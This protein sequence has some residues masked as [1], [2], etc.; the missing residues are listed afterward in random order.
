M[1]LLAH[2][3]LSPPDEII[4]L[5]NVLADFIGRNERGD[6]DPR[7]QVGMELHRK[8]DMFTDAHVVVSRSKAKLIGF[9]RYGNAL[10]DVIYD[11]FLTRAW[12]HE[13][14]VQD[15]TRR[16]YSSIESHRQLLPITCNQIAIRMIEQDWMG[17]YGSLDGLRITLE[18][19]SKR[20]EWSTGRTVD[21]ASSLQILEVKYDDFMQDFL[22]FWPDLQKHLEAKQDY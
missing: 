17:H 21:L 5:G 1:N 14:P 10:V 2:A 4:R 18:R 16:L 9:Q 12:S 19:M 13:L 3:V 7:V 8:I 20:I 22:E 6:L 15:F 11:H